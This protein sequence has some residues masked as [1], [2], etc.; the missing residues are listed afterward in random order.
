MMKL[1]SLM[2][3]KCFEI[4]EWKGLCKQEGLIRIIIIASCSGTI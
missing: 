1:T 4:P 3:A 2:V